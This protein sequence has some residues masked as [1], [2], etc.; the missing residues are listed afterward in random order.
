MKT[1]LFGL[2]IF[3]LIS[4]NENLE[5]EFS[6]GGKTVVV[7]DGTVI[8]LENALT[9]NII[10]STKVENN[11]FYFETK[12]PQAPLHT[13]LRTGSYS[14]DRIRHIW[15]ENNPM[16]FDAT[17]TDFRNAPVT[18]SASENLNQKL[19][20]QIDTLFTF[21]EMEHARTEFI[22]KHPNSLVSSHILS[23]YSKVWGKEK[24]KQL[25]N[26]LSVENKTSEYG[27]RINKYIDINKDPKVGQQ[28]AD[29]EMTDTNG[30][31]IK[32]SDIKGK[33]ILLEFW[34]SWCR[35]CRQENPN[36]V[37][38]YE[39]YKSKG[40]EI[41]AVSLDSNKDNWLKAINKDNLNW[42]HVSDLK[43]QENEAA[44]IYGV[45]AIPN[46]FLIDKNGLLIGR[47]LRGAQL[48][49]KLREIMPVANEGS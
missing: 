11:H 42:I 30:T 41:F 10:D 3:L 7:N 21:E 49:E 43:N 20:K 14:N 16:T 34:A 25:F 36:L 44:L 22:N 9:W 48:N 35:P 32:L 2:M 28:F 12:L 38:A 46:N 39:K 4:C 27:R 6:L 15:L 5:G 45:N 47:K 1:I 24:T 33:I 26:L 29:F 18:G 31:V 19:N 17:K 8:Y 40:F 13:V 37:K 23:T